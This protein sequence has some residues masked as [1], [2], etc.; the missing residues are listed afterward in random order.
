MQLLWAD[1]IPPTLWVSFYGL[2]VWWWK[3]RKLTWNPE[4]AT[5]WLNASGWSLWVSPGFQQG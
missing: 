1:I 3:D 2:W 4:E 5:C